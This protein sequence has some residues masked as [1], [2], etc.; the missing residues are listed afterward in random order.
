MNFAY[1]FVQRAINRRVEL[2]VSQ[3]DLAR[4]MKDQDFPFHQ[5]TISRIEAGE[6]PIRLDEAAGIAECLGITLVGRDRPDPRGG[7]RPAH[8]QDHP[9]PPGDTVSSAEIRLGTW[10]RVARQ[11]LGMSQDVL[12]ERMELYGFKWQQTTVQKTEA[13]TRPIRVNEAAALAEILGA[14]LDEM[15]ATSRAPR[16]L[17]QRVAHLEEQ[18]AE[19]KTAEVTR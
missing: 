5:T 4:R 15:T 16:T 19:L 14:S 9:E 10:V 6:R 7:D 13:A 8:R 3:T 2:G 18:V 12:A 1:D 11:G 17:Q